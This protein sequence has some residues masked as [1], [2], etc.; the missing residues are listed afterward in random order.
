MCG[1]MAAREIMRAG[2]QVAVV[3]KGRGVGGR[4]ATR[5]RDE[6]VFDHG[7]QYFTARTD[8]FRSRIAAW[9]QAGLVIEWADQF[10]TPWGEPE[11]AGEPRYMVRGGM[12][13]LAK[14]LADQ[15]PVI[16]GLEIKSIQSAPG[17]R[18]RAVAEDGTELVG[19][20]L[21]MTPPVP[22][23]LK[24]LEAGRVDLTV[25]D[26]TALA[27]IEYDSCYALLVT[28]AGPS[29]IPHPGGMWGDG[30]PIMWMADNHKKGISPRAYT[31]TIH[32]N[33]V[34]SR[35]HMDTDRAEIERMLLAAADPWL[36]ATV[37]SSEVHRWRYSAPRVMHTERCLLAAHEGTLVF[38]G[39]AFGG[40][41]V[42][43]AALS[44]LEAAARVLRLMAGAS[45]MPG[46]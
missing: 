44:G 18:W 24:L 34:W 43:G 2:W 7:A 45:T 8:E 17:A 40:A 5:R 14:S 31:I 15:M 27:R 22:Q 33:P 19:N 23:S 13:A 1:L 20:A 35:E 42:E 28:L 16:T 4:M 6:G 10:S 39:D 30:D 11:T 37:V 21:I 29:N 25:R 12:A 9:E 36:G 3:D 32:A 46:R 26:H 38:A 41:R